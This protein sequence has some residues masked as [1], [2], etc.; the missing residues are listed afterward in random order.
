MEVKLGYEIQCPPTIRPGAT[1]TF[2]GEAPGYQEV[3]KREGF[4]GGSG[5]VLRKICS[6]AGIDFERCNRTNVAKRRP[7]ADK[8]AIFYKDTKR[9]EPTAELLWWRQLLIAELEKYRPNIAVA[10]GNEALRTLVTYAD[11]ITKWQGSLLDSDTVP[12]LKVMP[13]VHP[14]W[15][16][17]DNWHYYYITIRYFKRIKAESVSPHRVLGEPVDKF[18]IQPTFENCKEWLEHIRDNPKLWWFQ[19]IETR[20]DTINCFGLWVEDRP[21]EA[22]CVPLHTTTGP[23]FSLH[24][25][26]AIWRLLSEAMRDNGN[27]SN[28]NGVYDLDYMLDYGCE[29]SAVRFDNMLAMN[30]LYPEFPKA[31]DF[32]ASIYTYYPYYKDE[33]KTW[34][35]RTPDKDVWNYNCKDMVTTPK[36]AKALVRDLDEHGLAKVFQERSQRFYPIAIEMQRNKLRLHRGWHQKLA[37]FLQEERDAKQLELNKLVGYEINVK[38]TKQIQKLLFEQLRLPVKK[39]RGSDSLTSDENALR[40]LRAQY[41]QVPALKLILEVRH[42]RTKESNYINVEFDNSPD[43][44]LYLGYTANIPG[45]KSGRWS[46]SSSPKWR[47]SSPQTIS[48]VMRLMYQPPV[49]SVFWQRDLS[50]AEARVVAWL[51]NCKFLLNVFNSPIKIHK[52]VGSRIFKKPPEAI[53]NDSIEYDIS[54]RVVHAY[55]YMMQYRKLAV[56]ANVSL[57]FAGTT[58]EEYGKEV[59]EVAAWH[60]SVKQQVLTKGVLKTP[61]G[62]VRQCYKACGALTHTGQLPDEILRDLVSYVPQSTVPDVLNEGMYT[63]WSELPWVRWHQQGHDSYLASGDPKRTQEFY[64]ISEKA[65]DVH[66]NINGR[67]CHIPGEFQWGYLWG[68]MLSYRPGEDTSYE[69]WEE[70]ATKEGFFDEAKIKEKLYALNL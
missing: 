35:K 16:M 26:A 66:F 57:H 53:L 58:L 62:R 4:I 45:T 48:K 7:P 1:I 25:E 33:G 63:V 55:N 43:G 67:D 47:G 69:A 32:Q 51:S 68:A 46:F 56:T 21:N 18:W 12:G 50:Q 19:D 29:P 59:P 10:L 54:K 65:A 41:P 27:W 64:E 44:E 40:E 24:E 5:S 6:S 14:A 42:L 3:L 23:Y 17:R 38:A 34:K 49:R 15:I 39:K 36:T 61:M 8:F 60:Q 20:G 30:V 11:S 9:T 31:L 70:R 13:C 52:L 22:I 2:I 37:Q 28:Q